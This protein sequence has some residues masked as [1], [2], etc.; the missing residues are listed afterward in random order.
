M[1]PLTKDL[2]KIKVRNHATEKVQKSIPEAEEESIDLDSIRSQIA[3]ILNNDE[4][5]DLEP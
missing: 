3:Y 2:I 5:V 1:Q 4:D